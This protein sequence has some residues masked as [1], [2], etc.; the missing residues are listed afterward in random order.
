MKCVVK[1]EKNVDKA[2]YAY[3]K[4]IGA[5]VTVTRSI[6]ESVVRVTDEKAEAMVSTGKYDYCPKSVFKKY[7][8]ENEN[9]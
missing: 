8:R 7:R 4:P 5:T 6:A 3:G 2:Y 9:D 1:I